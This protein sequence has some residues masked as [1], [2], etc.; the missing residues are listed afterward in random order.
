MRPMRW[1]S[2]LALVLAAL[3]TSVALW[4]L[5]R[6]E[7]PPV[8]TGPPRSDYF[9]VDFELTALD[10]DGQEAFQVSGPLLS[11]H[12][13]LGSITIEQPAFR[14]PTAGSEPW[15]A[16][17]K[18]A[19]ASANASQ[20]RLDGD[21]VL[22]APSDGT[23]ESMVFRTDWL[24]VFPRERRAATDA[25]VVFDSPRSILQG[26]GFRIDMHSRNYQLLN[27]VSGHYATPLSHPNP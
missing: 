5:Y 27:E 7:P 17:A 25:M 18:H 12:P 6:P 13:Y 16:H 2:I 15:T 1:V 24:D 9:L 4:L 26:R 8:L 11:R 19:W 23:Q 3:A 20:L 22:D 14:F 10:H 21:V